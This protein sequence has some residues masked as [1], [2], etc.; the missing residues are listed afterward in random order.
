VLGGLFADW[1]LQ[2]GNGGGG[3]FKSCGCERAV[4]NLHR[5]AA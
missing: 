3:Y 5:F 1:F 2:R 4:I